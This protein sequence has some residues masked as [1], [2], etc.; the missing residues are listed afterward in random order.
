MIP[1]FASEKNLATISD[2]LAGLL[3]RLAPQNLPMAMPFIKKLLEAYQ[4]GAIYLP[5]NQ[6]E[7]LQ[8]ASIKPLVG[9]AEK[10]APLLLEKNRLYFARLWFAEQKIAR[11][12]LLQAKITD[13]VDPTIV[14]KLLVSLFSDCPPNQQAILALALRKKLLIVSGGS[15]A[16]KTTLAAFLSA[17][18]IQF[19]SHNNKKTARI[20]IVAPNHQ[21][22]KKLNKTINAIH[23]TLL[24]N[25]ET[26]FSIQIATLN[27]CLGPHIQKYPAHPAA[28]NPLFYD[29][30]I[31]DEA[32]LVDLEQM[33]QLVDALDS[34]TRLILLGNPAQLTYASCHN[35]LTEIYHTPIYQNTTI[36]WLNKMGCSFNSAVSHPNPSDPLSDCIVVLN[37]KAGLGRPIAIDQ[38]AKLIMAGDA[39]EAF[40]HMN[41]ASIPQTAWRLVS[42]QLAQ[43]A[44]AKRSN[45][46]ATAKKANPKSAFAAFENFML[47]ALTADTVY[48]LN[49]QQED[50]LEKMGHKAPQNDWYIGRPVRILAKNSIDIL[51]IND[52]GLTLPTE[53][54]LKVF[55]PKVNGNGFDCFYPTH[56]PK[57]A[58]A[59]ALP[60][61]K[62]YSL[63]F[64]HVWLCLEAKQETLDRQW[65]D[66]ALAKAQQSITFFG[67]DR[68]DL[69]QAITRNRAFDTTLAWRMN[70]NEPIA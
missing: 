2:Q 11:Y 66:F 18:F 34:S 8:L 14:A 28:K 43:E 70:S 21:G 41:D 63:S 26:I 59:F 51:F 1:F 23:H 37:K 60:L 20:A 49:Q 57:C 27:Q 42:D 38:L 32:S 50:L 62:S 12:F 52:I 5:I 45:Y 33:A 7:A 65:L 40:A 6:Q 4:K 30:L 68:A 46:L 55:F 53:E 61:H 13:P 25:T 39:K 67:S 58:T 29:A 36:N 44:L 69:T 54:G 16:G 48:Q 47:F 3:S 19:A 15:G 31:V 35:I 64:N 17:L 10:P 9:S 56:L 24:K 22:V